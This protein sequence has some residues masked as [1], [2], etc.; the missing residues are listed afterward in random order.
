MTL[1]QGDM[2]TAIN[3]HNTLRASE[4]AA[5]MLQMNW[6]PQAAAFAQQGANLCTVNHRADLGGYGE[7]IAAETGMFPYPPGPTDLYGFLHFCYNLINF[8][9]QLLNLNSLNLINQLIFL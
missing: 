1:A 7:N 4:T 9:Y 6:D 5:N 2:N 3:L 8:N